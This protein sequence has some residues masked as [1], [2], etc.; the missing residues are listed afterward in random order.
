MRPLRLTMQAFGPYA[1]Q[2]EL[3]FGRLESRSLF[4]IH[5][6]TGS[7]KTTILDAMCFA[8]FGEAA[9]TDRKSRDVRSHFA[10]AP[11]ATEVT[12][13]FSL[14]DAFWRVRRIAEQMREGGAKTSKPGQAALQRLLPDGEVELRASKIRDVDAAIR[15]LL[16]FEVEQFRQVVM[17]PQGEFRRLLV[18]DSKDREKILERLFEAERYRRIETELKRA[19]AVL[20]AEAAEG[21]IRMEELLR[22]CEAASTDEARAR[23]AD[24]EGRKASND[25][26]G[27]ILRGQHEAA[28]AALAEAEK[29]MAAWNE[30][31]AADVALVALE[32][33]S[34]AFGRKREELAA[35]RRAQQVEPL[36][37]RLTNAAATLDRERR[38]LTDA[39]GAYD[40]GMRGFEA[41]AA[42]L[43]RENARSEERER[44]AARVQ[45]LEQARNAS[46][47]LADARRQIAGCEAEIA[48]AAAASTAAACDIE[49]SQSSIDAADAEIA[50]LEPLV[51]EVEKRRSAVADRTR[52]LGVLQDIERTR[53]Q[54]L[55]Q[56]IATGGAKE[57]VDEAERNVATCAAAEVDVLR[58]WF[59]GQASVLAA[60]L[61]HG[62]PCPVCGSNE[63]PMPAA[64]DGDVPLEADVHE[65]RAR[66]GAARV[67]L[68]SRRR[69]LES[70]TAKEADH[71]SRISVLEGSLGAEASLTSEA[72]ARALAEA[73]QRL[74]EAGK[75]HA[76]KFDLETEKRAHA[77]T[78]EAAKQALAAAETRLGAAREKL[79]SETARVAELE[80]SI[81]E[82]A[83]GRDVAALFDDAVRDETNARRAFDDARTR[84]AAALQARTS[85]ET[86][87]RSAESAVRDAEQA[88][89]SAGG[90]FESALAA[91]GFAGRD[92]LELARRAAGAI[93]ALEAALRRFD[94][95]LAAAKIR[96][97]RAAAAVE[98]RE[99]PDLA[100]CQGT[101]A[102]ARAALDRN[103]DENGRLG[104]A[105]A[106]LARSVNALGDLAASVEDAERRFLSVGR[107]AAIADG[108]NEAGVSLARFALG[109]LLDDVLTAATERLARMSQGRFALVRAG[110]RRDRRRSG[111]LDLEV[112]DSHTGVARPAATLS[113]GESFLASL[114][115]ALGLADIVQAHAGGI[116]LDTMF[117]DEGFGT[118][119]PEALDLAMRTLEDLQAG[120]RLVGII[121]HVPELKERV[122]ARLEVSA[123]RRGSTARFVC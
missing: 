60:R 80:R 72:A 37:E 20:E 98:G 54:L 76:R 53:S 101:A 13:E 63:H 78:I 14:G 99:K 68:D 115:L 114:A 119:D 122:G 43:D 90:D 62:A 10:D 2:V 55:Q 27:Q 113:G 83:A 49:Q 19:G 112:F 75:A 123:G 3:D 91:S 6:P 57:R 89:A 58:R 1:E 64:S 33:E 65:V 32:N 16:G 56:T 46:G 116:R 107:V 59:D 51:R 106:S 67:L 70:D 97:E 18:S 108:R 102:A 21:R 92:E 61:E 45:R 29:C 5:G 100:A 120:G 66:T 94:A 7:G 82:E 40:N 8:L 71:R 25:E 105:L 103:L 87:L 31:D 109:S 39:Q 85:A 34:T 22:V 93:D 47:R 73:E 74:V 118:L 104:E 96:A 42:V 12:L 86:S 117:I 38:R 50:A 24:C 52:V 69:E 48:A 36:L 9:G 44:L 79:A 28:I 23:L 110:D 15:E 17:L 30:H 35:A 4:L 77:S 95:T 81:P 111:G 41:A 26:Q 11:V 121:S 84:H 88:A